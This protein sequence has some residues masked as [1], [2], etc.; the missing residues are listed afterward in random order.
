MRVSSSV[1]KP[2]NSVYLSPTASTMM[3]W[4]AS[5]L[6][7]VW[8]RSM[9]V[10]ISGPLVSS[11]LAQYGL[12]AS[13]CFSIISLP[14]TFATLRKRSNTVWCALWSPWLKLSRMQ[15]MPALSRF[16]MVASSQHLGPMVQMMLVARGT[17]RGLEM[18]SRLVL[19]ERR[20]VTSPLLTMVV[21]E[22]CIMEEGRR[23]MEEGPERMTRTKGSLV[24]GSMPT[25]T[26]RKPLAS[27]TLWPNLPR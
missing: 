17:S 24:C 25:N 19:V 20:Q 3:G 22:G 18:R 23:V 27:D 7:G 1:L 12:P 4:L 13:P 2:S 8:S 5:R 15:S 10:R 26:A 16:A 21:P 14:T 9:A 11:R 6:M